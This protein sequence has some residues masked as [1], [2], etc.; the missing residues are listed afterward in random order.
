MNSETAHPPSQCGELPD[1]LKVWPIGPRR[2]A[3]FQGHNLLAAKLS[4][5]LGVKHHGWDGSFAQR[6]I[7]K[8]C[9]GPLRLH[10]LDPDVAWGLL[11]GDRL[12]RN[13]AHGRNR[14]HWIWGD[15]LPERTRHPEA[16]VF[17]LHQ[18]L[19]LW[20]DASR[21][22]MPRCGGVL[23][24]A[25]RE[26]DHL[27]ALH[28][29]L[30]VE[31]IPHGVDTDYWHPQPKAVRNRPKQICAVGRYLR[32]FDMLVRVSAKLLA[33]ESDLVIRWLVNPDFVLPP[34]LTASLP[35]ERF[36]IVRDLSSAELRQF[37]QESW[38]FFTPYGNVTASNAIVEAMACGIPVFTTR[39]GG[40]E[41][42]AQAAGVLVKDNDDS[43]ML[44]AIRECLHSRARRDAVSA[45]A[46]EVAVRDFSWPVVV[47]RHIAFYRAFAA[48]QHQHGAA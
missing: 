5:R 25:Q 26:C 29:E 34:E 36:Q 30:H 14:V 47:D 35:P 9:R 8:V 6:L 33:A 39:V 17:T 7:L 28:P 32:N 10:G 31:F 16:A 46:R 20:S 41:S 43:A 23:A 22:A 12:V 45:A 38:L 21:A 40:M 1:G 3:E 13:G 2:L 37:Y 15:R 4:A 48:R 19:E 44:A 18:P 42:Y 11:I 27:R 24:M